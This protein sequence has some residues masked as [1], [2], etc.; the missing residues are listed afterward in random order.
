MPDLDD[1]NTVDDMIAEFDSLLSPQHE[2]T[3]QLVEEFSVESANKVAEIMEKFKITAFKSKSTTKPKNHEIAII[4]KNLQSCT[5]INIK[6][7]FSFLSNGCSFIACAVKGKRNKRNFISQKLLVLDFDNG[8]SLTDALA[9][10][11]DNGLIVNILYETYTSTDECMKFRLLFLLDRELT[12]IAESERL[13]SILLKIFPESNQDVCDCFH[14]FFS[15]K[16]PKLLSTEP[17]NINV[18]LRLSDSEV[19]ELETDNAIV[20]INSDQLVNNN[21][22]SEKDVFWYREYKKE[23]DE[24]FLFKIN[25]KKYIDF[26]IKCGYFNVAQSKTDL[27]EILTKSSGNILSHASIPEIQR[28]SLNFIKSYSEFEFQEQLINTFLAWESNYINNRK[29]GY[30]PREVVEV[31]RDS[32]NESYLFFTN[33][34]VCVNAENVVLKHYNELPGKIWDR[35]ITPHPIDLNVNKTG[36]HFERFCKKICTF[37]DIGKLDEDRY[38]SVITSIGYLMHN[39]NIESNQKAVIF[40]DCNLGMGESQTNGRSGKT[41]LFKAIDKIRKTTI[42]D[43]KGIDQNNRFSLSLVDKD[44]QVVCYDDV[45]RNFDFE[46]LFSSIT[47]GYEV[48][49]KNKNRAKF[50]IKYN[51]KTGLTTNFAIRGSGGSF[52][53]RKVEIELFNYYDATHKPEHDFGILFFSGWDFNE[54]DKFYSF[55]IYCLQEYFKN[56]CEIHVHKSATL[57]RKKLFSEIG[58]DFYDF[59]HDRSNVA[60]D[61]WQS[62]SEICEK[63][64]RDN[65]VEKNKLI[66]KRFHG[67]MRKYC[68]HENFDYL[69]EKKSGTSHF[70]IV[71]L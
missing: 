53:D 4:N 68:H 67:L 41:L 37:R 19:V 29:I 66:A 59:V 32:E 28:L 57:D 50:S 17:N 6:E 34:F 54:W 42:L 14:I 69:T 2:P 55:M 22:V 62:V 25:Q 8:F 56:D 20:N 9:R 10:C 36:G 24:E 7:M 18:F 58:E 71:F 46:K 27:D 15:G 1:K 31:L 51:P 30:L 47:T 33:G 21:A 26:M 65:R 49:V 43:A 44:T 5:E 40:T 70:K 13:T 12:T 61:V 63:F 3:V 35:M 45:Q 23:D 64:N 16:N 60:V 38:R 39:C 48:E 11:R 52:T